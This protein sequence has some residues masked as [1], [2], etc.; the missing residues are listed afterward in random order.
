M[1]EKYLRF[2]TKYIDPFVEKAKVFY[3]KHEY[4][5]IFSMLF[6]VTFLVFLPF[7]ITNGFTLPMN[8]D[9][10][11]QQL[12]FYCE[13]HDAIWHFFKTG[14]IVMWSSTG[15]LGVNYFAANTFYYLSSPFLIPFIFTPKIL[16]PQM[17]FFMMMIKIATGGTLFYILLKKYYNTTNRTSFIG[18]AAYALSGWGMFYLWFN[19]FHDV[20]AV[21]PLLLIGIEHVI[22]NKKGWILS[23]SLMLLGM[24]NYF[25]LFGFCILGVFYALFR[26][27]QCYKANKGH[28]LAVL[29]KGILYYAL[30]ILMVAYVLLPAF[31]I[32][33]DVSRVE[34]SSLLLDFFKLIYVNPVKEEGG[35]HLGVL[36]SFEQLTTKENLEAIRKYFFEFSWDENRN[37]IY[38]FTPLS[39]TLFPP[40]SNWDATLFQCDWF[41]NATSSMWIS[42]PVL[43]LLGIKVIRTIRAHNP[44][45]ISW[46]IIT[47][48]IP[49]IPFVYYVLNAFSIVYGRWELFLVAIMLLNAIPLLDKEQEIKKWELDVSFALVMVLIAISVAVAVK[50]DGLETTQY[51]PLIVSAMVLYY[52]GMYIYLRKKAIGVDLSKKYLSAVLVELIIAGFIVQVGQGVQNYWKLYGS[53][54]RLNDQR[55]LVNE[56]NKNDDTFFR[57][58]NTLADRDAN[59]L[60]MT[61]NYNGIS[62][63]HSVYNK[64]LHEFINTYSRASY[65]NGN[66]SMGIDEKRAYLNQ[67]L[68]VK[69][70]IAE[71]EDINVPHDYKLVNVGKYF[72]VYENTNFVE[73][74]YSVDNIIQESKFNGFS[75][76]HFNYEAAFINTAAIND[77][78]FASLSNEYPDFNYVEDLRS[79][80]IKVSN[81]QYVYKSREKEDEDTNPFTLLYSLSSYL[82]KDRNGNL[83]GPWVDANLPGDTIVIDKK[84]GSPLIRDGKHHVILKLC[85]GPNVEVRMY[86][87]ANELVVK[88]THGI[89]YYDHSGDHKYARGFYTDEAISRI[90]IELLNDCPVSNFLK[91]DLQLYYEDYEN[92]EEKVQALQNKKVLNVEHTKNTFRF[93]TNYSKDELVVLNVPVDKGWT[94]T[95]DGNEIEYYKANGGFISFVAKQG[96]HKYFLSYK[97]PLLMEGVAISGVSSLIFL[98]LTFSSFYIIEIKEKKLKI[99]KRNS[100]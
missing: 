59:N 4:F 99:K 82:S 85:Y 38:L 77:E 68:G 55:N 79:T 42:F 62:A 78:D 74:G 9:Y 76:T 75:T 87:L 95:C 67:F 34:G 36:K 46:M 49:F 64:E 96:K 13:A 27:F 15:F 1:K 43:L 80:F 97:T 90:E 14:E 10:C 73:L 26:Y 23:I 45:S 47:I 5:K 21:F 88:D 56:I 86:N 100:K 29:G 7:S 32:V 3:S 69:Y 98:V 50:V 65:S 30:G 53:Q 66:W 89:N 37:L 51:R 60:S 92:Y 18:A 22:Q 83:Y 72:N 44:W 54:A 33:T 58:E 24:A 17:I 11:L 70:L 12:H 71:N 8:G 84:N 31:N 40:I 41:D 25:F 81:I 39:Q 35:Y 91:H 48:S 52:V 6:A 61:L 94:L 93:E 63:F 28:N 16:I 19:H 57:I 20:L 2:K